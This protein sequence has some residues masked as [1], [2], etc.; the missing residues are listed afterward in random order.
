MSVDGIGTVLIGP[1]D[2]M[3]D[4]KSRGEGKEVH[5][6]L[7]QEVAAASKKTGIAAGIVVPNADI[8][9]ERVSQGFRFALIGSERSILSR[10]IGALA[11]AVRGKP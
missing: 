5:E 10:A 3:L 1:G 7:V 8:A 2:L 9:R 11:E 6:S 4:V